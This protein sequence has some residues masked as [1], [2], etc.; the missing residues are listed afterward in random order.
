M[1]KDIDKKKLEDEVAKNV[2]EMREEGM[3]EVYQQRMLKL[4]KEAEKIGI[5]RDGI[6]PEFT[7]QQFVEVAWGGG[8]SEDVALNG[9][10]LQCN[11]IRDKP[12]YMFEAADGIRYCLAAFDFES[13]QLLWVRFNIEGDTKF[14]SGRDWFRWQPPHPAKDTG[15]HRVCFFL[16]HQKHL[17]D[18][19]KLKTISKFS[20]EGRADF[21]LKKFAAKFDLK[22]V[23]GI[24]AVTTSWDTSCD[25]TLASLKPSV[26]M[27]DNKDKVDPMTDPCN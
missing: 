21:C 9:N 14:S 26:A 16:F 4:K 6:Y 17:Q 11:K 20:T 3:K 13:K 15:S 24:N 25:T 23:I 5:F 2:K 12:I 27:D 1:S 18:M 8:D 7:P 10:T 19:S 22:I